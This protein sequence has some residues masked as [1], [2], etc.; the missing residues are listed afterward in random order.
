LQLYIYT[1]NRLAQVWMHPEAVPSCELQPFPACSVSMPK[2]INRK[3]D[4]A[5]CHKLAEEA[6]NASARIALRNWYASSLRRAHELLPGIQI[7]D[8]LELCKYFPAW[9]ATKNYRDGYI[10]VVSL[11]NGTPTPVT[12]RLNYAEAATGGLTYRELHR[13]LRC[14]FSLTPKYSLRVC[15]YRPWYQ[16]EKT[17]IPGIP[18][19][20]ALP[21]ADVQCRHLLGTTLLFYP[22]VHLTERPSVLGWSCVLPSSG[23][24]CHL[25]VEAVD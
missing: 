1:C 3:L 22:Y 4:S 12:L 11:L 21:C 25:C 17:S 24:T 20:R 10:M 2:L 15:P 19:S 18:E 9:K 16:W 13:Q 7:N 14:H 6:A 23:C 5:E 8:N